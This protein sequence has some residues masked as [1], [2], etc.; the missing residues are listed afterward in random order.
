MPQGYLSIVLHAHL[1]YVRHPEYERFLEEDWLF[2]AISETYVPLITMLE[3]VSR[4]GVRNALTLSISPT[5]IE[6]LSDHFLMSRYLAHVER[7]AGLME[8]EAE[9]RKNTP[10]ARAALFYR[11]HLRHCLEKHAE[12]P[13]RRHHVYRRESP[14]QDKHT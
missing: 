10:F 1:P 13:F 12:R 3:N 8:E 6:M 4:R 14:V 9:T 5:L 2:E 11:D 7:L